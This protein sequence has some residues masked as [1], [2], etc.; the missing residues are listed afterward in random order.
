MNKS[1]NEITLEDTRSSSL[2]NEDKQFIYNNGLYN[3]YVP[4]YTIEDFENYI[5]ETAKIERDKCL[6]IIFDGEELTV[7]GEKSN[8]KFN[9]DN[10]PIVEYINKYEIFKDFGRSQDDRDS[11]VYYYINRKY[12]RD[13]SLFY[14]I[15]KNTVRCTIQCK[16]FSDYVININEWDRNALDEHNKEYFFASRKPAEV[17]HLQLN[18][19]YK[20]YES[21]FD[22]YDSLSDDAKLK[23]KLDGKITKDDLPSN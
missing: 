9:K 19:L 13:D 7:C 11:S 15:K 23:L 2:Y 18:R 20:K 8:Y 10:L 14:I 1:W 16:F 17:R 12:T 22:L 5:F 4:G 3:A 21:I 6:L